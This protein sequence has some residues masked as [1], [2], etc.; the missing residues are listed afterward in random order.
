MDRMLREVNQGLKGRFEARLEFP[1]WTAK[2]C[3]ATIRKLAAKDKLQVPSFFFF[4][5]IKKKSHRS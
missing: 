5:S 1:N 2:D 4:F 3:A